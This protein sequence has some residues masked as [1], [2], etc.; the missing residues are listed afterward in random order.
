MES[1]S[2]M[3]RDTA[4]VCVCAVVIAEPLLCGVRC[5]RTTPGGVGERARL[6]RGSQQLVRGYSRNNKEAVL[7]I[8]RAPAERDS[9]H[10]IGTEDPTEGR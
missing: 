10:A 5:N 2:A 3:A 6:S 4:A 1:S 7:D 8:S 9:G